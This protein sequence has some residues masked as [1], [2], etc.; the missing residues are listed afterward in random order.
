MIS[1]LERYFG[2]KFHSRNVGNTLTE[3]THPHYEILVNQFT[4]FYV[5][6]QFDASDDLE[7]PFTDKN[8]FAR[9]KNE[10]KCGYGE[11]LYG[12]LTNG[13]LVKLKAIID[14]SD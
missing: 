7:F 4:R 11:V 6:S 12:V 8:M 5:V 10:P 1:N 2:V 14:S 9:F 3:Y 13:R